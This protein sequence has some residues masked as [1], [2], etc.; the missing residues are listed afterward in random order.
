MRNAYG[1]EFP[2]LYDTDKSVARLWG[3]YDLLGD[4]VAAPATFII[5]TDGTVE[6]ALIGQTI[7]DRPTTESIL[8][9]LASMGGMD[10]AAMGA[11]D[12]FQS[13]MDNDL[14]GM[15]QIDD[16]MD[17][18]DV[19]GTPLTTPSDVAAA[20]PAIGDLAPDFELPTARGQAVSLYDYMG[21]QN[22]VLVFFRA[23]W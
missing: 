4:G 2:V 15:I 1:L 13:A 20:A 6:S 18:T 14:A 11:T 10:R 22:V 23:W 3:V 16:D 17:G 7:A 19:A 12:V 5:R 8:E 9:T 21:E